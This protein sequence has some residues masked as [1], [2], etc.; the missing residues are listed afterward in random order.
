MGTR[1]YG[2]LLVFWE[3]GI[4]EVFLKKST[5]ESFATNSCNKSLKRIGSSRRT[6]TYNPPVNR[7]RGAKFC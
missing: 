7:S 5:W 1:H 4:P 6:R 3:E 2:M